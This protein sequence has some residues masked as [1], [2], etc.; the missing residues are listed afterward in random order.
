[1][2][3]RRQKIINNSVGE[4]IEQFTVLH[5]DERYKIVAIDQDEVIKRYYPSQ[6]WPFLEQPSALDDSIMER[7]IEDRH[8]KMNN[9]HG[10]PDEPESDE[11]NVQMNIDQQPYR[12]L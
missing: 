7:M 5:H 12:E 9:E 2:L 4:F 3:G 6:I 11:D 1:M 8:E 10:E